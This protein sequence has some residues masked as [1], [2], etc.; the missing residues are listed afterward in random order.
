MMSLKKIVADAI[1]DIREDL[2]EDIVNRLKA[3]TGEFGDW[4]KALAERLIQKAM[5]KMP[6]PAKMVAKRLLE[7]AAMMMSSDKR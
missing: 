1:D 7:Q 4:T 2:A 5:D 6:E 3:E